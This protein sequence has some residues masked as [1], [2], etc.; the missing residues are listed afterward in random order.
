MI[1]EVCEA[2]FK[3]LDTNAF[4]GLGFGKREAHFCLLVAGNMDDSSVKF[5]T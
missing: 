2:R 5:Q 4:K 3:I 1:E